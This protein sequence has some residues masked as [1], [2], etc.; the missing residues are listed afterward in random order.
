MYNL[1]YILFWNYKVIHARFWWEI[2]DFHHSYSTFPHGY[3]HSLWKSSLYRLYT[4]P[5]KDRCIYAL[6]SAKNNI[7]IHRSEGRNQV[8]KRGQQTGCG[9]HTNSMRIFWKSSFFHQTRVFRRQRRRFAWKGKW[10]CTKR[11]YASCIKTAKKQNPP[12]AF[13]ECRRLCRCINQRNCF[14]A[15]FIFLNNVSKI[16]SSRSFHISVCPKYRF[17]CRAKH[18]DGRNRCSLRAEESLG[19][20]FQP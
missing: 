4:Q 18:S 14:S 15:G 11:R 20:A 9:N 6:F 2:R 13:H 3:P 7:E 8:D 12:C 19:V 16:R 17:L 10:D 5:Y 1:L